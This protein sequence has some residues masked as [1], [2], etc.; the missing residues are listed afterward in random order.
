MQYWT[1][2]VIAL[3]LLIMEVFS[4]TFYS[5]VVGVAF[6]ITGLCG[7]FFNVSFNQSVVLATILS[8][9]GIVLVNLLRR[10]HKE[11]SGEMNDHDDLDVG[12]S[13]EIIQFNQYGDGEVMYR[14]VVWQAR[15]EKP[16]SV[17]VEDL[18][19]KKGIIVEKDANVLI[20]RIVE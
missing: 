6:F 4:L 2:M 1:W 15:L 10:N 9:L 20:V 8:I 13:V 14:G 18:A 3:V 7:Y 12:E 16:L 19:Q 11:F 17:Q 5:L